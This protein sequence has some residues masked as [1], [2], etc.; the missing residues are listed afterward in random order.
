M[1]L[2]QIIDWY[3]EKVSK[4]AK[5]EMTHRIINHVLLDYDNFMISQE[6][7]GALKLK[8]GADPEEL[9]SSHNHASEMVFDMLTQ[10]DKQMTSYEDF[11]RF[12]SFVVV[13]ACS[14]TG[15]SIISSIEENEDNG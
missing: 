1:N 7:Q 6:N 3:Y 14:N 5:Q 8:E 15:L 12:C 11:I 9:V 2:D 4:D 10:A 13:E